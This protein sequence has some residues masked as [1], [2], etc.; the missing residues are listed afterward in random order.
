[1]MIAENTANWEIP[2]G[3]GLPLL[4]QM[5]QVAHGSWIS[6]LGMWAT[7][8]GATTP[9]FVV[10]GRVEAA[11]L[12][13]RKRALLPAGFRE[14]GIVGAHAARVLPEGFTNSSKSL[15]S[16]LNPAP[17]MRNIFCRDLLTM[18]RCGKELRRQL[19]E[20]GHVLSMCVL[21]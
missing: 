9:M 13:Q 19:S 18:R 8:L 11:F 20:S 21:V 3:F 4:Y 17:R 14:A 6:V 10:S 2:I 12:A 7:A 5:I 1:M 16:K 15:L